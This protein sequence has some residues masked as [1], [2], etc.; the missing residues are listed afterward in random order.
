MD[1]QL[2]HLVYPGFIERTPSHWLPHLPR[3]LH[4]A[5]IRMQK[6]ERDPIRDLRLQQEIQPFWDRC[7]ARMAEAQDRWRTD[8]EFQ[9]YRWMIEEYRVSLF[10][11]QLGVAIKASAKRLEAQWNRAVLGI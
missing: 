6:L 2:N 11:Q 8:T 5:E 4:A 9:M 7:L 3:Y 1:S 10:A